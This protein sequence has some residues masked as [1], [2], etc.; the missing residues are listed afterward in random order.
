MNPKIFRNSQKEYEE[1]QD[2][3]QEQEGDQGQGQEQTISHQG[4][5]L[6]ADPGGKSLLSWLQAPPYW[7]H[8]AALSRTGLLLAPGSWFLTSDP[9]S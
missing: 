3:K 5:T 4:T 9:C 6:P 2:K 8:L 1:E 7:L